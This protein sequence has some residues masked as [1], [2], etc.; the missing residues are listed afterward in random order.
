MAAVITQCAGEPDDAHAFNFHCRSRRFTASS[1]RPLRVHGSPLGARRTRRRRRRRERRAL[2]YFPR[3]LLLIF[4]WQGFPTAAPGAEGSGGR[5]CRR[6]RCCG[7]LRRRVGGGSVLRYLSGISAFF[8]LKSRAPGLPPAL[9]FADCIFRNV[10]PA[11]PIALTLHL[12][13]L[14]FPRRLLT[15]SLTALRRFSSP[16]FQQ[17][18]STR[19]CP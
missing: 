17:V 18:T 4:T 8:S 3:R 9:P 14:R 1:P 10:F 12:R 7:A 16:A 13:V 2:H 19:T 11:L 5:C 15:Y 6:V